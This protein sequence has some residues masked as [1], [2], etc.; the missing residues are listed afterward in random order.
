MRKAKLGIVGCG[1]ISPTYLRTLADRFP[2]LVEIAAC[3]DLDGSAARAR[4][5][6]FRIPKV[7][8]AEDLLADPEIEIVANLT[9]PEAHFALNKAALM[10]GKHVYTEKPFALTMDEARELS[11]L[12][13]ERELRIAA[14]PDTM[15]GAGMQTCRKLIDD[16]WLGHVLGF[17][18]S[19]SL[20]AGSERYLR[21]AVGPTLDMGPYYVGAVI[22][23]LGAIKRIHAVAR[24]PFASRTVA[25]PAAK[26]YGATFAPATPSVAA[27][28]V[29]L[30]SGP[31]GTVFLCAEAK[32]YTPSIE[33]YGTEATLVC[34]DANHC[35]GPVHLRHTA[36]AEPEV[37]IPFSFNE[38]G[39]RGLGIADMALAIRYRRPHRLSPEYAAHTTEALLGILTAAETGQ[40]VTLETTCDRPFPMRPCLIG[41]PFGEPASTDRP[42]T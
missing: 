22:F 7:L 2:S 40:P 15:L 26:N 29:E 34:N 37:P 3:A 13:A 41:S 8:T 39:I 42:T 16:G 4:A 38:K 1:R 20:S 24:Y 14:A 5:E 28:A 33:I 23:L 18:V 27:A 36:L 6:E 31:I 10:A 30:V 11:A 9:I 12:A 32:T 19:L 21:P 17:R 25:D 35:S